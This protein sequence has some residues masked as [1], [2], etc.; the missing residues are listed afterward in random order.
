MLKK[1]DKVP[2]KSQKEG[3]IDALQY[4]KGR[5]EGNIKSLKTPWDKF[6]DATTD[7]LEWHTVTVIGGRPGSGKTLIKDQIVKEA[8]IL[9][10]NEDF[11][12]LE[13]QLEMVGRS[14]AIREFSSH[15]G[16]TY[17]QLCSAGFKLDAGI[18][19][20]CKNYA[21][22]RLVY[23]INTIEEPPTVDE[24]KNIVHQ[25]M[26]AFAEKKTIDVAGGKQDIVVYKKT[27]VTLDHSV[28][29]KRGPGEKD[30]QE[31]LYHLGE[32]LTYLKRIYP[33]CFI[34]L[35]QLNRSIDSPDRQED[36][37]YGNYV[38]ESD[39]FGADALL[40]HADN[41]IGINRPAKQK[42]KF[43]GPDRYIIQDETVLVMHFL[44]LRNGDPR[45]SFFKAKYDIMKVLDAETPPTAQ[46]RVSTS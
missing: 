31:T 23:P 40:Q 14:S 35:S 20:Q 32:T 37:K 26:K 11:K 27:I 34:I 4:M 44:K 21:K 46:K 5:L 13:F 6:N 10:P 28:L 36:G 41:V 25:Y 39:L 45:M 29:L 16:L 22:A 30:K 8:F 7:G 15:T 18:I 17:K 12:V 3:F 19:D 24:F 2:W 9:N 43:Y 38:L 1:E 33:I 42:I